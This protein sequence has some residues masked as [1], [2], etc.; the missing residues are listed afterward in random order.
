MLERVVVGSTH[1][2][3]ALRI[4]LVRIGGEELLGLQDNVL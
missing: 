2:Q 3:E 1:Q 4:I